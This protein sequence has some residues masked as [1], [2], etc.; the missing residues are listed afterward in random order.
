MLPVSVVIPTRNRPQLLRETVESILGGDRL[1]A[2]LVVADQSPGPPPK[3]PARDQIDLLHLR[4]ASTGPSRA[5]NA[6]IAAAHHDVLVFT[7]DDVS[8]E[9]DWLRRLVEALAAAPDRAAVTG[10]VLAAPGDGH[11]PSTTSRTRFEVF[12]GRLF[13]DVLFPNNMAIPRQAF[14]EIGLFDE[15]LGPGSCFPAAEDNDLGYRLLD[16]GYEIRFVPDA[17]LQHRGVRR[18]RELLALEW[19]YGRGQGA[20]YAKHMN[21]TDGYMARRF[22]R[23]ARFRLRRMAP[24]LHGDRAAAREAV[25]LAG[26]VSGAVGWWRRYG[27]SP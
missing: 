8:V 5:R 16:A 18:G 2:E 12:S 14:E 27:S 9:R 11:V 13:A 20:F 26:L 21:R 10:T 15:R 19:A 3:L 4:L 22:G 17:V 23:N 24:L 25:Y 7:D 6:G 1:P